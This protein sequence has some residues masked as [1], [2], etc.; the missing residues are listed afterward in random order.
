MSIKKNGLGGYHIIDL[1]RKPIDD[2]NGLT[3]PGIY[4]DIEGTDKPILVTGINNDGTEMKPRFVAFDVS[5]TDF[6][7]YLN[8]TTTITI[9]DDDLV[10]IATVS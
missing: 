7:G 1:D 2:I 3:V 5:G 8:P 10:T 9:D 4:E 6:V